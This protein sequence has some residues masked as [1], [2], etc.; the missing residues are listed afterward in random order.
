LKEILVKI[1]NLIWYESEAAA[2]EL[3]WFDGDAVKSLFDHFRNF[4]IAFAIGQAGV[5]SWGLSVASAIEFVPKVFGAFFFAT[6]LALF[7]VNLLHGDNLLGRGLKPGFLKTTVLFIYW[8]FFLV[9]A[10]VGCFFSIFT[11]VKV[12]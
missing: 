5:I 2:N 12:G 10:F 3:N 4:T 7:F 9:T 8:S 11:S 1:K 6:S